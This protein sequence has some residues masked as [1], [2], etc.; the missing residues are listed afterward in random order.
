MGEHVEKLAL[1]SLELTLYDFETL[2]KKK[3][4]S[5][6]K[7]SDFRG[8]IEKKMLKIKQFETQPKKKG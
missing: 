7:H 2:M 8:T 6:T 4:C 5:K 1:L 3:G